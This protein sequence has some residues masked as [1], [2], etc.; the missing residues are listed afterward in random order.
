MSEDYI[1]IKDKY[2][3]E[4][5]KF[6]R[7]MFSTLLESEGFLSNLL[8]STFEPTHFLYEDIISQRKELEF[9]DYIFSLVN[10]ALVQTKSTALTPQQLLGKTGYDLYECTT[11]KEIQYFK[12]YYSHNEKLCTFNGG[13]LNQCK[14]FFAV[15]KNV[16]EIKRENFTQPQRQD[17]YGT[18]VISI[19]FYHGS[20]NNV[21]IKNRYNHKVDNPDSTFNNNLDNIIPGLTKSFEENY[22]LKISDKVKNNFEL[23]GYIQFGNRKFYKYNYEINNIYYCINNIVIDNGKIKKFDKR[24]HLLVDYFDIN[25]KDKKIT[26]IDNTIGDSFID[27]FKDI[28]VIN[29]EK[30][31]ENK[32]IT[33]VLNDDESIIIKLNKYNQIIYYKNEEM[34]NVEDNFLYHNSVLEEI[35]IPN[36]KQI[37]NSFLHSNLNLESFCAPKL[38][39]IGNC[40][41]SNN[42]KL[43]VINIPGV[44]KIG[45]ESL[46]SNEKLTSIDLPEVEEIGKEFLYA[47]QILTNVEIPKLKIMGTAC[48]FSNLDLLEF[49]APSLEIIGNRC[50]T[51]NNLLSKINIS[52]VRK[53]GNNFLSNNQFLLEFDAPNVRKIGINLLYYNQRLRVFNAPNLESIGKYGLMYSQELKNINVPNLKEI[54]D[55]CSLYNCSFDLTNVPEINSK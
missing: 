29:V 5:A 35:L 48:F 39:Y 44:K 15:K 12:K 1:R 26:L 31:S 54:G 13:R 17:E 25:F 6:C 34:T 23:Y 10:E 46:S 21:S 52:N 14:V 4:M 30:K 49:D 53:I 24:N 28:K 8:L 3:E 42:K 33:L 7:S 19:Q 41:L 55:N 38:K 51:S 27:I 22:G 37:G 20:T 50:L 18:S 47:N 32:T 2:G 45:D 9:K 40:F 11:E 43:K 16:D 36:V